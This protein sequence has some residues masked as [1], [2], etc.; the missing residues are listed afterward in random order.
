MPID[1]KTQTA[2]GLRNL[3]DNSRRLHNA[4]MERAVVQEMHG[5][6][7]AT[8][9]EYAAFP[10]NQD[11]VD[12]VMEPFARIAASVPNNQRV[13]Y[14]KAGGRK[15]G[16]PKE[17]PE[18][19]WIDSYSAIKVSDTNAVFGCEVAKPGNDPKFTLYLGGGSRREAQPSQVYNSDQLQQ[20]FAD[21]EAI[22]R[23]A[24]RSEA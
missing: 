15:I 2:T 5:R 10:W 22:A 21:W 12:Q 23:S 6:G 24:I 1:L 3:L 19:L 7:V 18:H 17:H 4:E 16:L 13:S 14:T 20:A 8:G 9:R 11:R